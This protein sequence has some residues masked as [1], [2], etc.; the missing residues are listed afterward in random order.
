MTAAFIGTAQGVYHLDGDTPTPLG[1]DEHRISAILAWR[2]GGTDYTILAGSYESGMFR[3]TDSGA[4]WS[5]ANE[6]LTAPSIRTI[7]H[8]P[9]TPGGILCGTEPARAYI[10]TDGGVSWWEFTSL[11]ELPTCPDW[12]LPYSP[13]AGAIRNFY[14]PP[15]EPLRLLGAI[16][17]GGL[18]SSEDKGGTWELLNTQPDD[19]IHYVTGHPEQS[20]VLYAA[21][22]WASMNRERGPDAPKLGGVARSDDSGKTWRKFFSDYTR[23]VIVPPARPDLLLAAPALRVGQQGRIDVSED[24]GESWQPASGGLTT[25]MEDMV[26]IFMPA[27]HGEIWGVCSGGRLLAAEPGEWQW[28]SMLPADSGLR[29]QSVSFIE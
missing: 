21:L 4:T 11:K 14:S 23:A 15:D 10:T 8:D 1:L 29:A 16:E 20:D 5:P 9:T 27:P 28:R 25:P 19:D 6:G 18:L 26:E 2:N 12:Y 17:V 24:G 3:S 22:G 13:R 7:Q